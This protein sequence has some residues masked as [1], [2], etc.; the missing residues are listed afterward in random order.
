MRRGPECTRRRTGPI[1]QS[2]GRLRPADTE[3][4]DIYLLVG[5]LDGDGSPPSAGESH[6]PQDRAQV[7]R[8][9]RRGPRVPQRQGGDPEGRR[10][11]PRPPRLPARLALVEGREADREDEVLRGA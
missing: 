1:Y 3:A 7:L 8:A 4:V 10:L 9:S 5:R 6:G 11:R 2:V